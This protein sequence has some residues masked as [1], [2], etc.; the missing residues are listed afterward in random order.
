LRFRTFKL[1]KSN[2]SVW[3]FKFTKWRASN[4][5]EGRSVQFVQLSGIDLSRYE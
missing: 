1:R 5:T 2:S 4:L 3:N